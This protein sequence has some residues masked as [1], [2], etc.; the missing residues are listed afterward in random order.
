[1]SNVWSGHKT[2]DMEIRRWTFPCP[3]TLRLGG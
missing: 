2:L 1:M 3:A